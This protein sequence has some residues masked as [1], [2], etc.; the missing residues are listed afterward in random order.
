VRGGLGCGAL[1]AA[2]ATS[3]G[4]RRVAAQDEF[5]ERHPSLSLWTPRDGSGAAGLTG[6]ARLGAELGEQRGIHRRGRR[7]VKGVDE[8]EPVRRRELLSQSIVCLPNGEA[9]T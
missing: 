1:A 2:I 8:S 7:E 9:F 6:L 4:R 3:R 5:L